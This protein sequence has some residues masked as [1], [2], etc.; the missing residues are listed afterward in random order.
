V[1]WETGATN[2]AAVCYEFALGETEADRNK[3]GFYEGKRGI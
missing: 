1:Q 3:T 2:V